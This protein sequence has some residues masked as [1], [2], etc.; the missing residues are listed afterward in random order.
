MLAFNYM[1][2]TLAPVLENPHPQQIIPPQIPERPEQGVENTLL[3]S[4]RN[5]KICAVGSGT[6]DR[7]YFIHN[8]EIEQDIIADA[9]DVEK[10]AG[11]IRLGEKV[12]VG[13]A[14]MEQAATPPTRLVKTL[15][16][17]RFQEP[18]RISEKK[19][20]IRG[21]ELIVPEDAKVELDTEVH[22]GGNAKNVGHAVG[23]LG[24]RAMVMTWGPKAETETPYTTEEVEGEIGLVVEHQETG[25]NEASIVVGGGDRGIVSKKAEKGEHHI[26]IER[27]QNYNPNYVYLTSIGEDWRAAYGE[28]VTYCRSEGVPLAVSPGS[29][30]M[31]ETPPELYD[32]ISNASIL[33]VN[34]EEA[35]R[36]LQGKGLQAPEDIKELL[37]ALRKL[38]PEGE[39]KKPLEISLT[40]G[41]NGSYFYTREG[42]IFF[43]N[44]VKM[45][46][47]EIV[48]TT[49]AGD[50][51]AGSL[52]SAIASENSGIDRDTRIKIGM[53][54]GALMASSV[55]KQ[56]GAQPG[57][58]DAVR[59][60][61]ALSTHAILQPDLIASKTDTEFDNIVRQL[62]KE[63]R[64]QPS[65]VP[66]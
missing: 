63:Q 40:D 8:Y 14:D 32:A 7:Y 48:D 52:L 17:R 45:D 51:Y 25:T 11:V 36:L 35:V 5:V 61:E 16:N 20:K 23:K 26:S 59:M 65:E 22:Q 4:L 66:A 43:L 12:S 53:K 1:A 50:S 60:R 33:F 30:Q 55:L 34:R 54:M 10:G 15:Q 62:K 44:P 3:D 18:P 41:G 46:P 24:A 27:L 49:G 38:G 9:G 56:K 19:P 2:D 28:T 37:Y 21:K 42:N 57:M 39:G 13:S 47:Q 31:K 29:P 64:E 58:L 6:T